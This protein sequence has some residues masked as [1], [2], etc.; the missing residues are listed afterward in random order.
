MD[1]RIDSIKEKFKQQGHVN[2]GYDYENEDVEYMLQRL[3]RY[4]IA[5]QSI[6]DEEGYDDY[7]PQY[8]AKEALR[9]DDKG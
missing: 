7:W 4:E 5:L 3:E 1:R 8:I 2:F 6:I 9:E